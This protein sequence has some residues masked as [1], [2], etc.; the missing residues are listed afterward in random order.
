MCWINTPCV[1]LTELLHFTVPFTLKIDSFK[2]RI[3]KLKVRQILSPS[4]AMKCYSLG[5]H[6]LNE[7]WGFF[8]TS[9]SLN[10][11]F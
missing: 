6:K 7:F 9:K 5:S 2:L 1:G 8:F 3:T 10:W 4:F 11:E